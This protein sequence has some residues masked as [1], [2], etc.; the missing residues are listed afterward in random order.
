[1]KTQ[2]LFFYALIFLGACSNKYESVLNSAPKPELGF[3]KDT[4]RIREKDYTNVRYTNN[5]RL[6]IYCSES[7]H[8]LNLQLEDTSSRVHV[9]YRGAE[10][11]SGASLPVMDSIVV[12]INADEAGMYALDFYLSDRLGKTAKKTLLVQ[13]S[14]NQQPIASFFFVA[15]TPATLQSWPYVFDASLSG[16]P[17]GVITAYH[18]TINGQAVDTNQPVMNW[19]F[20]A[21]GEHTIELYVTDDLGKNSEVF[22]KKIT[23]P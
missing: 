10:I 18:F 22:T 7:G 12:F 20:H 14:T 4:V 21:K 11:T 8:E 5:G 15:V 3:S 13:C 16:K 9:I 1:M 2:L 19:T 6:T 23:I 17:D